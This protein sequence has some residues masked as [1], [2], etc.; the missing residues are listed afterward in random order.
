MKNY[1]NISQSTFRAKAKTSLCIHPDLIAKVMKAY[2]KV[3]K[4]K[5][6]RRRLKA[7]GEYR[8]RTGGLLHAMQAL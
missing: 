6:T 3:L 1:L 5:A 8:I 4:T 2:R 7:C